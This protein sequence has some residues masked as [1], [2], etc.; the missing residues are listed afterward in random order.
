M[1][2]GRERMGDLS[3]GR[4]RATKKRQV[5]RIGDAQMVYIYFENWKKERLAQHGANLSFL[6][7]EEITGSVRG[8]A[9]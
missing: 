1:Q 4:Q 2:T 3:N 8:D 6:L 5:D 9:P 7:N